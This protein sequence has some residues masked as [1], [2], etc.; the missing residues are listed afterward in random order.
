MCS[1][2]NARARRRSQQQLL[3]VMNTNN[4]KP[5]CLL[6]S[7]RVAVGAHA[8]A[9]A[10][11]TV[12]PLAV[13]LADTSAPAVLAGDPL[14]LMLA[15]A[16]APTVLALAPVAVMLADAGAPAVLASAPLAYLQVKLFQ[17]C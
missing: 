17:T 12:A 2:Q 3:S 10:L 14:E 9:A 5:Y 16:C 7:Y 13:M 11:A 4:S 6:A 8:G 1:G 15:D